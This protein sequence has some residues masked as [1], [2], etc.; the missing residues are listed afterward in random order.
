C[1][2]DQGLSDSSSVPLLCRVKQR[3]RA[4]EG[5]IGGGGES[6]HNLTWFEFLSNENEE[7]GKS[8]KAERGTKVKRRL[9]S[10]RSR[11]TGS[12]QKEKGKNKEREKEAVE[13]KERSQCVH[14]HQLAPGSFSSF[15]CC[16][17]CGKAL[18]A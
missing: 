7:S 3:T 17:L 1:T 18:Q 13:A 16:T 11:V 14:G 8:D 15:T 4:P 5:S 6:Q 9:S 12:W 2:P 10:L